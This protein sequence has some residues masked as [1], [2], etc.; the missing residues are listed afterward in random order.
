MGK[1]YIFLAVYAFLGVFYL[2]KSFYY[3]RHKATFN[4]IFFVVGLPLL[5]P[6]FVIL[7]QYTG[8]NNLFFSDLLSASIIFNGEQLNFSLAFASILALPY[9][10][11]SIY[12]LLRAFIRYEF[13][14]WQAHSKGGPPGTLV[15]IILAFLIGIIYLTVA[16][17]FGDLLIGLFGFIYA[18][19]G[20]LAF[21]A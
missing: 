11:F 8:I 21:L 14:R 10:F 7:G 17:T 2:F 9:L 18:L 6:I 15:G 3:R 5:P 4:E 16:L 12:L 19:N 20:I 1:Q 13:I